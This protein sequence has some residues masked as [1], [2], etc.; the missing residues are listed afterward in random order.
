MNK[1]TVMGVLIAL[2][3]GGGGGY[4]LSS[5]LEGKGV[6]P[7]VDNRCFSTATP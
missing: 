1:Q 6:A 3:L 2:V 7:G 4:W 5:Y